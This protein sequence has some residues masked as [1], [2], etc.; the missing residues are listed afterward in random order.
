MEKPSML[1]R[2][3]YIALRPLAVLFASVLV[4]GLF[5]A[6][7]AASDSFSATK[8]TTSAYDKLWPQLQVVGDNI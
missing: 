3:R 5:S 6:S 1:T 2:G 8:R 7:A 4:M